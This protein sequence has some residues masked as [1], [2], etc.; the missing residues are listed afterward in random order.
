MNNKL[1]EAQIKA[2]LV[3]DLDISHLSSEEQA[4]II[5]KMSTLIL[6]RLTITLMAKLPKD[7]MPHVDTLLES[8]QSE[9]VQAIITKHVKNIDVIANTVI[10]DTLAEYKA[11]N[12]NS[13]N[14]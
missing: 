13:N 11:M 8:G 1:D 7:V 5:T 10:F 9:A 4:K 14:E 12:E 2:R 6:D 3:E